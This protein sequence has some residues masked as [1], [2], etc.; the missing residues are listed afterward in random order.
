[1]SIKEI[2]SLVKSSIDV[3]ETH[4]DESTDEVILQISQAEKLEG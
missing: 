3:L 2:L 1:M 4:Y